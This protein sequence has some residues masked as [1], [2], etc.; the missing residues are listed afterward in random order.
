MKAFLGKVR[1]LV[2]ANKQAT[3]GDLIAQLNPVIAAGRTITA[4]W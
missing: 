2:K 3:T 4:L 1:H